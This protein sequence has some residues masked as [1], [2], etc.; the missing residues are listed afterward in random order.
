MLSLSTQE[1]NRASLPTYFYY[2]LAF[3][4][5][6]LY[7]SHQPL[8]LEPRVI[9]LRLTGGLRNPLSTSQDRRF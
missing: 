4:I 2:L 9:A 3:P 7:P 6:E 8:V 5:L 1:Q